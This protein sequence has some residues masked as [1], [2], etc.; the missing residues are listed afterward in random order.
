[1]ARARLTQK[2]NIGAAQRRIDRYFV[3]SSPR[4]LR[5]HFD[6]AASVAHDRPGTWFVR[7]TPKRKQIQEGLSTLE[8]WV[9]QTSAMLTAMRMTFPSGDSKLMEFDD[10]RLNPPLDE[11]AFRLPPGR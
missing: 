1:M 9:D 7:M 5:S 4:E 3:D 6:I 11:G 10:V 2:T 8:L